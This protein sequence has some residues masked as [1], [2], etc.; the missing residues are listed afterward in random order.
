MVSVASFA[1]SL[2]TDPYLT[3]L[4]EVL[5]MRSDQPFSLVLSTLAMPG[6]LGLIIIAFIAPFRLRGSL[7]RF[8][9]LATIVAWLLVAMAPRFVTGLAP[10]LG[11]IV[12]V[13]AMVE[14]VLFFRLRTRFGT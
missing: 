8:A 9:P 7:L 4:S 11:L 13:L 2:S 12:A 10:V 3:C 1:R 6:H 5:A 14:A